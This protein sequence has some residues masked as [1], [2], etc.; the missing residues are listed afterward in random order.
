MF[1]FLFG[2][3]QPTTLTIE[4]VEKPITMRKNETILE[5]ALRE[6]IDFPSECRAGACGHCKCRLLDGKVKQRTDASMVLTRDEVAKGYVLGC[7][8]IPKTDVKVGLDGLDPGVPTH[9]RVST[10]ATIRSRR[11][12]THDIVE[13]ELALEKPMVFTAG[14]FVR[15]RVPS[16]SPGE[17]SYSFARAP[18]AVGTPE[19]TITLYVREVPGGALSPFLVRGEALSARVEVDG[20]HGFFHLRKGA[21]PAL[22]IAGGSGLAPI[23][24]L[25]EQL[26][27]ERSTRAIT[28]LFGA[29]TQADLYDVEVL[30]KLGGTFGERFRFIPVLSHEPEGSDWTGARGF[31]TAVID[32]NAGPS[33]QAYLCGPPPMIDAAIPVLTRAGVSETEIYFDKF[34]DES[35]QPR[36]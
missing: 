35:H 11:A 9:P 17:R 36:S 31:V 23:R 7:Q 19:S 3:S 34:L 14:Q 32:E 16:V 4:G 20:P 6:G 21:G 29:R 22:L 18:R 30:Q 12:L 8:S 28:V 10:T 5:A 15:I 24:A 2:K 27:A 13:L 26:V 25:L 1:E 33:T